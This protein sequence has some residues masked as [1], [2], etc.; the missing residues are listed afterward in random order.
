V[1]WGIHPLLARAQLY[2]WGAGVGGALGHGDARSARV[3]TRVGGELAGVPLAHI[4]CGGA[5]T[6]G[7]GR[8]GSLWAWGKNQA[9]MGT[10]S[11]DVLAP[12]AVA[13]PPGVRAL[14]VAVGSAHAAVLC[15]IAA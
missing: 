10:T 1:R 3:P 15:T 11:G 7:V 4:A 9:R 5:S 6:F 2:T 8:D 13:L 12:R 14:S